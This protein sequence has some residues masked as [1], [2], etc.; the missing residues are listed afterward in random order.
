MNTKYKLG[1]NLKIYLRSVDQTVEACIIGIFISP[2]E[3]KYLVRFGYNGQ[4]IK[5]Y[6]KEEEINLA[7]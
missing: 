6:L 7:D 2:F 4:I 1:E 3:T 5:S